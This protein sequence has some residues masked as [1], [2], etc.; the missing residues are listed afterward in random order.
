MVGAGSAL[1]DTAVQYP[2]IRKSILLILWSSIQKKGVSM[3]ESKAAG[4]DVAITGELFVFSG[5]GAV[6][7]KEGAKCTGTKCVYS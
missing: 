4:R 5:T 6:K 7:R 3:S 1:K 2:P